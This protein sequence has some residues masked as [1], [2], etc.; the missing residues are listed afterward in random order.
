MF[1]LLKNK[2]YL[3]A[4]GFLLLVSCSRTGFNETKCDG[5]IEL[6]GVCYPKECIDRNCPDKYF[7]RDGSCVEITCFNVACEANEA[8]VKGECYPKTCATKNCPG[9]GE[10]CIEEECVS[11]TC[12]GVECPSEQRCANGYCYP[13]NC[14]TQPC[15]GEEEVCIEGQCE[16]RSCVGLS[17][18]Q[19]Q[20]CAQGYCYPVDCETEPCTG[21]FEVCFEGTCV[22]RG[23][24]NVDCPDGQSC[25]GGFCYPKDCAQPCGAKEVCVDE[26][27]M[28]TRCVGVQCPR[29]EQCVNGECVPTRSGFDFVFITS[30]RSHA[31]G[32]TAD[33]VAYC[34][35]RDTSGQ[36][37]NGA[38]TGQDTQSPS[39]VDTSAI[40]GN[41]AF[42]SMSA[43]ASHTCGITAEGVAYCWGSDSN[44]QLGNGGTSLDTQIPSPVDSSTLIG[45]KAF[46]ELFAGHYQTCGI[47]ADGVAYCWGHDGWGQLGNGGTSQET[48]SPSPV[49]TST[50]PGN[51]AFVQLVGGYRHTCGLTEDGVAYCWGWDGEGQLGNGDVSQDV[52]SPSPVDT[53]TILGNKA[54]VQL[55]AGS[56][57]S[58]GITVDGVAYCW[59]NDS[60]GRLGDGGGV[61][62]T[63]SPSLVDTSAIPSNKAFVSISTGEEHTCSLTADG[64]ATCW[65]GDGHGQLGNGGTPLSL[66]S[67][68]L[69]DVSAIP[70]NKTFVQLDLGYWF[71]CGLTADGVAYC[72]G[73]DDFGQLGNGAETGQDTLSPS[74]VDTSAILKKKAFVKLTGGHYHTCGLTADGVAYCWGR[75]DYGQLGNGTET[76]QDA[77]SP[78]PVDTSAIT[79]NKVFVQITGGV[80]HTCGLTV[81]GVAYCWGQDFS[82]QLGDGGE[83]GE[84]TQSPS[85]VDTSTIQGNKAFVELTAGAE[86]TCGLTADGAAYCWGWD[87]YGQLGNGGT[88]Q[89]AQSPSPVDTSAILGNKAFVQLTGG[90]YF[91][92]G[93]TV[94]GVA[95]CWGSDRYGQLGNGGTS[96][97]TQSPSLV[98]TSAIPGNKAFA[99]LTGAGYHI[100]GLTSEGAAYCWGYDYP[101]GLGNGG[102]GVNTQSPSPVDTTTISGDKAFTQLSGGNN[103]SCGL[104]AEGV[105]YCWGSDEFGQLGNEGTSQDTQSPSPVDASTIP[106]NKV[107]VKLTGGYGHACGLT[108]DGVAYCWGSDEFGQLGNGGGALDTQ[109]PSPVDTT[110]I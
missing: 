85:P 104:T 72:W 98:D 24:V 2:I 10:V 14:E 51:K 34:W 48:Q 50:I 95:Y 78:S 89:N 101:G 97:D 73:L 11:G 41:K 102:T 80:R 79:G 35:G 56:Y 90:Y 26:V 66:Q 88:G 4:L 59:G 67:P 30:G 16:Q 81:E 82:G 15:L 64:L 31:C 103:F 108:A 20:R 33:G 61:L 19:G 57:H 105:T 91:T 63:Q 13:S 42:V 58:C 75:D 69:V 62:N 65:G 45:S 29:N 55:G 40:T 5:G 68:S 17:C 71:T 86:H 46:I 44:G 32:L 96:L 74:Q 109:S 83:T 43:G 7:C 37:G 70:G 93:L 25:A 76:G 27:C 22:Y 6:D 47:T 18:P 94:E 36:L 1:C 49:D 53:S 92:C 39:L 110:G 54:F 60:C 23:C 8:C 100:C 38:E 9:W 99:K 77:Q 3:M 21:V 28:N 107:F 52:Q 87:L 12:F 106:G 84:D